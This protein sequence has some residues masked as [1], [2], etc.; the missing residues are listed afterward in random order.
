MTD[1]PQPVVG[2]DSEARDTLTGVAVRLDECAA[3]IAA[4]ALAIRQVV[5]LLYQRCNDDH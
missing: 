1:D 2:L 3:A 5:V 4:C